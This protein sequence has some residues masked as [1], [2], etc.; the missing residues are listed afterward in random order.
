MN[1]SE[2][3][4]EYEQYD[5]LGLKTLMDQ[6]QVSAS[7]VMESAIARANERNPSINAIVTPLYDAARSAAAE[8]LEGPLAGIPFLIK[9]LAYVKDVRCSFGSR[10]WKDF[11][12]D[13]D[14]EIVSRYRKA[15][16]VIMGKTNTP[17]VGL[18]CT[19]EPMLFGPSKNPWDL[20]RTT[21]GSSGGAAAAVAAGILPVAHATDGGGSIRIPA[22][23]CGLV[24]LK[25]TR[26][27]TPLGPDVGEGWGGMASAHVVSRSVRDSAAFLDA[28]HGPARGDPYCAPYFAGSFLEMLERNPGKL[29]IAVDRNAINLSQP[30]PEVADALTAA[31]AL[32]ESLGH[33]V[34]EKSFEYDR[35]SVGMAASALVLTNVRNNVLRRAE[36]L[37]IKATTEVIEPYTELLV[38]LA[39]EMSGETYARSIFTIHAATRQIEEFFTQYDL[40]LSPT[41]L[42]PPPSLGFMDT[43]STDFETYSEHF[44]QFWGYT[45]LYNA[46][47]NPAISLPLSWSSDNL[48]IGMQFV[49]SM[50]NESLLFQIS[51]QLEEAVPWFNKRPTL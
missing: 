26:G 8:K 3:F 37:G 9:D 18:A 7:E 15:G 41:V 42:M 20:S 50:G 4:K 32:C 13:H 2:Q 23:C 16:L 38:N 47:G 11:I 24:G 51:R 40:I 35:E 43:S 46:T 21:G 12:P 5:A 48:P 44:G 34:E 14:G 39:T 49:A 33:R 31:A 10:L 17:E 22:S 6:E 36:L 27:R 1:L 45:N 28:T 19:T 25:P 29:K 30:H